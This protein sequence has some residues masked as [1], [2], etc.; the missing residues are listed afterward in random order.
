M[1]GYDNLIYGSAIPGLEA[2]NGI[3]ADDER[4]AHN[5]K[6]EN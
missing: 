4:L 1:C 3:E 6:G 5:L 2:K